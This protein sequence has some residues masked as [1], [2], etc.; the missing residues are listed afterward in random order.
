MKPSNTRSSLTSAGSALSRRRLLKRVMAAGGAGS[1]AFGIMASD[2]RAE[3]TLSQDTQTRIARATN[4][5]PTPKIRD[6]SFIDAFSVVK[7]TTDQP[8]LYGYGEAAVPARAKLVKTAL[9]EYLKPLVI[10]RAVDRIEETWQLLFFSSYYKNDHVQNSALAGICDALWDIKGRQAGMPVYQLIGGKCRD[11]ADVYMHV[12]A[13]KFEAA[14]LAESALKL[15]TERKARNIQIDMFHRDAPIAT[16]DGG[17]GFDRDVAVRNTMKAFEAF[18]EKLPPTVRLGVDVHSE[19][20]PARA[21][22]F[23]KDA[24]Q[25]KPWYWVEDI[26]PTEHHEYI[27][28]IR[29]QS[30]VPLSLGE[31]WNNPTEWRPVIEGRLVNYFR[32]HMAHMGG[33]TAGRKLAAFAE[34]FEVKTGWHAAGCSPVGHMARLTLDVTCPNFGI[35]ED[36]PISDRERQVFQGIHEVRDGFAWVSEKPGWG[37]EIDEAAAAKMPLPPEGDR[38]QRLQDGSYLPGI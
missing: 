3:P 6:V 16:L 4:G 15:H 18:R 29:E 35:H 26:V 20:D 31:L 24:E 32:N 8:G 5:M 34:N 11:A 27:R 28:V 33:F 36:W 12:R 38:K 10:G 19:L 30:F 21:L 13:P 23:A 37:I 1:A 22:Q 9:L 14:L 25:F 7:V 17:T 2:L